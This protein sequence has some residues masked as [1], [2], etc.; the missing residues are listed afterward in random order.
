MI[1][2]SACVADGDSI[3][4][5]QR[6]PNVRSW[7]TTR[8][9]RCSSARRP[10]RGAR[11]GG[12][13]LA[14]PPAARRD[15]ADR[16]ALGVVAADERAARRARPR[17]PRRLRVGPRR[18]ARR[19]RCR[20]RGVVVRRVR[21]GH[22]HGDVRA[23]PRGVPARALL[24][25]RAEAT[26]ES[27]RAAL[28]GADVAAVADRLAAAVVGGGRR[29]VARCSP[30]WRGRRGRTTRSGGCGGPASWRA[31]TAATATSRRA[32]PTGSDPIAMNVL[33]EVWVGMPLGSYSATRGW[34]PSRSPATAAALRAAG[35]LDGDGLSA[36]G[37]ARARRL[38]ATT[39]AMEQS[40]VDA[41][42]A[43]LEPI[44][45]AARRVVGAVRRRRRVP[46]RRLQARRRLAT[47]RSSRAG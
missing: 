2:Q 43:D 13:R 22:A 1:L 9:S 17:L 24:A 32:S 37:R 39:D 34:S 5:R 16:H 14:R 29:P 38:E 26:I 30:G 3:V 7:T 28:A 41:L 36:A 12:R 31:S 18:G 27:L 35:L 46:A 8:W 10:R 42:G 19:T 25:A 20:R 33:T 11:S 40:I 15:R 23:G 45:A 6:A 44:V 21:A 47:P 4:Q